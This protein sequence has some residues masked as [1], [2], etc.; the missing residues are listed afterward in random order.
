MR[1][2]QIGLVACPSCACHHRADAAECPHCGLATSKAGHAR[3]A[4]AV[5]LGLTLAAGGAASGCGDDTSGTGGEGG[6]G[7]TVTSSGQS[8]SQST[9]FAVSSAYGTSATITSSSVA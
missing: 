7:T 4:S 9:T 5:L 8:T 6:A 1:S 3:T 2:L